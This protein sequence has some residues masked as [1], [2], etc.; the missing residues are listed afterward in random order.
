[1]KKPFP[2]SGNKKIDY[3]EILSKQ[4]SRQ[5]TYKM[6]KLSFTE[7]SSK[8]IKKVAPIVETEADRLRKTEIRAAKTEIYYLRTS[9]RAKV[10][11]KLDAAMKSRREEIINCKK[12]LSSELYR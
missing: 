7:N 9:K 8:K 1:V 5:Q 11:Y 12:I 10:D 3:F 4:E 2:H 6:A